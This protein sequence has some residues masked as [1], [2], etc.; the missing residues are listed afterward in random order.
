MSLYRQLRA[1]QVLERGETAIF[2]WLKHFR[3]GIG[4]NGGKAGIQERKFGGPRK[5][6]FGEVNEQA[7]LGGSVCQQ[8]PDGCLDFLIRPMAAKS[9][10]QLV[11]TTRLAP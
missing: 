1:F 3:Q 10:K 6:H 2:G 8:F 7:T 9:P 4:K 11:H 5:L